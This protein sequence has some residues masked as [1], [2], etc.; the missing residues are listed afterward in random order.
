MTNCITRAQKDAVC[1]SVLQRCVSAVTCQQ[2]SVST[3]QDK[4]QCN[5]VLIDV[6]ACATEVLL[7]LPY[8]C[9]FTFSGH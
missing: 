2:R 5:P 7:L 8:G 6:D 3:S 4:I 1:D 9:L